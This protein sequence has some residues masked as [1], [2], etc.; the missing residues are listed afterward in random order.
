MRKVS[1]DELIYLYRQGNDWAYEMLQDRFLGM[2]ISMNRKFLVSIKN[3]GVDEDECIQE[4]LVCLSQSVDFYCE[5]KN[6]SFATYFY[7]RLRYA[8]MN[9][10]MRLFVKCKNEFPYDGLNTNDLDA[11]HIA[12]QPYFSDPVKM[13]AYV[14]DIERLRELYYQSHGLEKTVIACLLNGEDSREMGKHL[15]IEQ[16]KINNALY[17]IRKKLRF[18]RQ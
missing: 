15:L 13:L 11:L 1:D 8:L 17:R 14:G 6:A 7:T 2:I 12:N 16:R 18:L 5:V 9:Y 10:R 4:G 3:M